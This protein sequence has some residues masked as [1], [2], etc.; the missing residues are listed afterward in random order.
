MTWKLLGPP[1]LLGLLVYGVTL[2][3]GAHLAQAQAPPGLPTGLESDLARILAYVLGLAAT[4]LG[5]V[6]RWSWR[7]QDRLLEKWEA[8]YAR[9]AELEHELRTE[10]MK[11]LIERQER[12][13]ISLKEG[14][15]DLARILKREETVG[16]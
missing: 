4:G 7:R 9:H 15:R 6:I 13:E 3:V 5:V 16:S 10:M 11:A 8:L 12:L 1:G 2:A 14:I